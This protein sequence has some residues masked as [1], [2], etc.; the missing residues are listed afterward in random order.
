MYVHL[1]LYL[2]VCTSMHD[3]F[4]GLWLNSDFPIDMFD[5]GT[6]DSRTDISAEMVR[7]GWKVSSS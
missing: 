1:S 3:R 2:H 4:Y 7:W 5:D 6:A